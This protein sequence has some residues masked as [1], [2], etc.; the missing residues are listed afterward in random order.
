MWPGVEEGDHWGQHRCY[1][2]SFAEAGM[3]YLTGHCMKQRRWSFA[4]VGYDM[5]ECLLQVYS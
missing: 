5:I 4:E 2:G 3:N 1:G